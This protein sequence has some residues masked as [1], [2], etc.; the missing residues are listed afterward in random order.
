MSN[1]N[2]PVR[3]RRIA[4]E[5]KPVV[6]P[7]ETK[8]RLV[9]KAPRKPVPAK[10]VPAKPADLAKAPVYKSTAPPSSAPSG[11]PVAAT[12][13]AKPTRAKT[14]LPPRTEWRWFIPLCLL[15]L[16][17][18]VFGAFFAVKGISDFREQRGIEAS[19]TKAAAAAGKA[20]ET[21]FS[22]NYQ[23]L[24]KHA[25]DSLSLMTPKYQKAFK[26]F[27]SVLTDVAT[28]TKA[29]ILSQSRNAAALPCGDECMSTKASILVFID[30]AK[31]NVD[32]KAPSVL[33]NR[34]VVYMVKRDGRWLVDN[35]R[36]L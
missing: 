28:Q 7:A 5:P 21:I 35:I 14:L 9:P 23:E 22:Y 27:D 34:M 11:S 19:N 29:V 36:A 31:A 12:A 17:A 13:V 8:R 10:T 15:A 26:E 33:G 6:E 24:P 16:G 4:G 32:S 3:R 2:G 30:Q 18:V 20:A 1:P 25:T